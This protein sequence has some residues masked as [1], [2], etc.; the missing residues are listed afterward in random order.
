MLACRKCLEAGHPILPGAIFSGGLGARVMVIGQAPGITEHQAGRPFNATSGTRLFRWLAEA[1]L[2]EVDYRSHEYLTAVTKCYPGKARG[3]GDRV[4]SAEEQALCR[5]LL[6][7][8]LALIQ[9]ELVIPVGRL[10]IGLFYPRNPALSQVIGTE[11][12]EGG[13][14]IVPLPHPSG[15]SRWHQTPENQA[16]IGEAIRLIRRRRPR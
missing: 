10:A 15:A 2:D 11:K 5:P 12:S 1:G 6:E 8:E 7:R 14:W 13:R 4:P 16:R 3:G 9:P